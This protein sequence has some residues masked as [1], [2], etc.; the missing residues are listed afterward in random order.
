[1]RSLM[2]EMI[3]DNNFSFAAILIK[4]H[5]HDY[6]DKIEKLIHYHY[7]YFDLPLPNLTNFQQRFPYVYN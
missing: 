6:G 7:T 3:F 2:S 4:F 1:M 5:K